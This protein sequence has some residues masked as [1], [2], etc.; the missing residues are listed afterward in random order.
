[1]TYPRLSQEH[2]IATGLAQF[3]RRSRPQRWFSLWRC[4]HSGNQLGTPVLGVTVQQIL[5]S[6]GRRVCAAVS[7]RYERD[8]SYAYH[9]VWNEFLEGGKRSYFL[10]ACMDRDARVP[11]L[12]H[13]ARTWRAS[14]RDRPFFVTRIVQPEDQSLSRSLAHRL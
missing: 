14:L 10:L 5:T 8:Y 1:M 7:K 4:M 6:A 3:G 9:P 2:R 12:A 13:V 11:D